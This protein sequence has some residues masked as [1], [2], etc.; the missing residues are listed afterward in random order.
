M[1]FLE[2]VHQHFGAFTGFAYACLVAWLLSRL[3]AA[4]VANNI[5][6]KF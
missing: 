1:T 6:N 4:V 5:S 2:L 3:L